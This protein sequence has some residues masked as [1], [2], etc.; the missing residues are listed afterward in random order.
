MCVA[1]GPGKDM[2]E[3]TEIIGQKQADKVPLHNTCILHLI[4][5]SLLSQALELFQSAN[6][7]VTGPVDFIHQYVHMPSLVVGGK[8]L[9]TPAMGYAFAAGTTDGCGMVWLIIIIPPHLRSSFST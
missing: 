7:A 2:F 9:C 3:S 5:E 8:T 4:H 1:Y 6:V